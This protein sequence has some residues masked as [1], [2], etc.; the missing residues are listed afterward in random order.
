M[1]V[2]FVGILP[3]M[4]GDLTSSPEPIEIKLFSEDTTALEEKAAE[5]EEAIQ[6]IQGVEDTLSG[7]VVSGPAI[8]FKIDPLRAAQFGV[9][10]S[11]VARTATTAMSGDAASA[12]LQQDR[13]ITVR[14]IFP[15]DL[16]TSLEKV[17][18]L[19]VRSS[20]GVLFRLDQVADIEYEKGQTEINR[21]GL[22]QT[23]AVTGRLEDK[24]LGTGISEIQSLLAREVKRIHRD[25]RRIRRSLQG[26]ASELSRTGSRALSGNRSCLHN[27]AHRIPFLCSPDIDRSGR[28]IGSG[29]CAIGDSSSPVPP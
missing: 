20:S 21:D 15:P 2:E 13:L 17:R 28:G 5:V 27:P 29:G 8:T 11:D 7:V 6:K 4:I 1:D 24:D 25:D 22:R 19:K 3:D 26:T 16:R 23:V 9:N 18:A 10:A 14:V 12:I